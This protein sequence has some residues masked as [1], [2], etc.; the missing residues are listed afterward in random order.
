MA[1]QVLL[2]IADIIGPAGNRDA[3]VTVL[4]AAVNIRVVGIGLICIG[5]IPRVSLVTGTKQRSLHWNPLPHLPGIGQVG[6]SRIAHP[7]TDAKERECKQEYENPAFHHL[8]L[9]G[10]VLSMLFGR[11]AA[12][13]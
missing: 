10:G 11:L 13:R 2:I 4:L 5:I 3:V 7:Y 1:A 12:I 9:P 6:A 8:I